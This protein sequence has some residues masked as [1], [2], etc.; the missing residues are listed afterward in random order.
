M[1][2]LIRQEIGQLLEREV[3]DPRIG[4]ATVTAVDLSGDLRTARVFVSVLG[5][6]PQKQQALE[7]LR[8]ASSFL[9]SQLAHRLNLRYTPSI[10]F[11]LDRTQEYTERIDE[12]IRRTK[13]R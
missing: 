6:E 7:G 5:E 3:H 9:R 11:Q 4:F 8:A 10:E 1:A 12:L 2:D 13:G